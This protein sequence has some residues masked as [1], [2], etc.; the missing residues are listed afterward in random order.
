MHFL[1][2]RWLD[3]GQDD[4]AIERVLYISNPQPVVSEP[5]TL[6][7]EISFTEPEPVLSRAK[8]VPVSE[9]GNSVS[10]L[11]ATTFLVFLGSQ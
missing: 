4:G 11:N 1:P 10:N 7:A 6:S 8:Q 2:T 3:E 9:Q 5:S